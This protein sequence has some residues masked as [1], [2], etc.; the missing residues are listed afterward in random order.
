MIVVDTATQQMENPSHIMYGPH[1]AAYEYQMNQI[2]SGNP[3]ANCNMK[4]YQF[5]KTNVK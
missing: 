1:H 4:L 2:A 3:M 5:L